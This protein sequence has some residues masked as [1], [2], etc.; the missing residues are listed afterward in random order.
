MSHRLRLLATTLEKRDKT[1][2]VSALC[3]GSP[4]MRRLQ[5]TLAIPVTNALVCVATAEGPSMAQHDPIS[6]LHMITQNTPTLGYDT[7]HCLQYTQYPK[8]GGGVPG[9]ASTVFFNFHPPRDLIFTDPPRPSQA[10]GTCCRLI[11]AVN[12]FILITILSTSSHFS[13]S[14]ISVFRLREEAMNS[15]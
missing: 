12:S 9:A 1:Q 8:M 3:H 4:P 11:S 7:T 2:K 13:E 14:M 15:R 5:R 10:H 6:Q